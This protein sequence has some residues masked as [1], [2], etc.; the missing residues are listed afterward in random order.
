MTNNKSIQA[1]L[2][3]LVETS[4]FKNSILVIILL[5]SIILGLQTSKEITSAVGDLLYTLDFI[6]LCIFAVELVLKLIAYRFS[7]FKSGFNIFD[8]VIVVTSILSEFAFLSAFRMLRTFRVLRSLRSLRALRMVT[9]ISKLNV[10]I[11][12]IAKSI[13]SILWTGLLLVIIYYVFAVMGTTLFGNSFPDWFGSIWES[14]YTLF[15]VMTLESWS[16]GISRPVMD[17]YPWAWLYFVPFVLISAFIMMNVVVGIVVNTISETTESEEKEEL[18]KELKDEHISKQAA[19]RKEIAT[20]KEQIHR[21][22]L[23][24]DSEDETKK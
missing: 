14:F 9:G 18:E 1:K 12:A 4:W 19:L 20:L 3:N 10:I 16:M 5:N 23:L 7:F 2:V 8:F 13:P 6:C 22:E 15:Q 11:T 24:L 17:V 21:V